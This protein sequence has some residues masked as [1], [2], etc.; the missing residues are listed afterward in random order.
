MFSPEYWQAEAQSFRAKLPE[1]TPE[2]VTWLLRG[3]ALLASTVTRDHPET[4]EEVLS[5]FRLCLQDVV[6][7]G[8]D[9]HFDLWL[10]DHTTPEVVRYVE[11]TFLHS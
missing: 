10:R 6:D 5:Q 4:S 7:R 2:R 8:W 9:P 11:Q 1:I 3:L